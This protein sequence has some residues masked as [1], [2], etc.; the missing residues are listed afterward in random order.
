M[1][2]KC[3]QDVESFIQATI[4]VLYT[5]QGGE[6]NVH[7][8]IIMTIQSLTSKTTNARL[9]LKALVALLNLTMTTITK[10]SILESIF[11]FALATNNSKLV[12]NFHT[13]IEEWIITWKLSDLQKRNLYQKVSELLS[14]DGKN[15]LSLIFLIKYFDT[16]AG[17]SYPKDVE[18]VMTTAVLS[19]IKSPVSSFPDRT[20]LLEVN[21]LN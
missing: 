12:T 15:S 3:I 19:A 16:F 11:S 4:S 7:E 1:I 20:A 9:R 18:A 2:M 13:R 5:L 8:T 17:E 14:A 10:F 21:H 6:A